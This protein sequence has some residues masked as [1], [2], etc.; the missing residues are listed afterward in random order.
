MNEED[1]LEFEFE[2]PDCGYAIVVPLIAMLASQAISISHLPSGENHE[3][4]SVTYHE[5]A[6]D[7][8]EVFQDFIDRLS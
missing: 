3:P 4:I 7:V 1:D 2:C 8:P 6:T 5:A